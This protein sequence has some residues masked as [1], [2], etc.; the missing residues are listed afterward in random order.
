VA[1]RVALSSIELVSKE[2]LKESC[3]RRKPLNLTDIDVFCEVA[4]DV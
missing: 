4:Q 2:L 3:V 1:S